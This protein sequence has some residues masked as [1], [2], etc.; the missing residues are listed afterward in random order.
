MAGGTTVGE[1]SLSEEEIDRKIELNI[2]PTLEFFNSSLAAISDRY[3]TR[4][5]KGHKKAIR[6]H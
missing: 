4:F 1:L 6:K 3:L 2:A 5:I